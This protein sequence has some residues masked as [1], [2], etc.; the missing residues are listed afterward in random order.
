MASRNILEIGSVGV[1]KRQV[2]LRLNERALRRGIVFHQAEMVEL[3]MSIDIA[4]DG[5]EKNCRA[6]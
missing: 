4:D 5:C 1:D 6:R 3:R 2:E